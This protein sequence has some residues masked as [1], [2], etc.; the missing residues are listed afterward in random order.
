MVA[1]H[2][3]WRELGLMTFTDLVKLKNTKS[4]DVYL[5]IHMFLYL[6]GFYIFCFLKFLYILKFEC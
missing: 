1:R 6:N 2:S 5:Q 4:G 3:H